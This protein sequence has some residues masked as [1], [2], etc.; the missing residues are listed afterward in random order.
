MQW[1]QHLQHIFESRRFLALRGGRRCVLSHLSCYFQQLHLISSFI[2]R[3]SGIYQMSIRGKGECLIQLLSR[4]LQ[5][6]HRIGPFIYSCLIRRR[7]VRGHRRLP[8]QYICI[9]HRGFYLPLLSSILIVS[10]VMQAAVVDPLR[11]PVAGI[12]NNFTFLAHSS[13]SFS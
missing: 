13:W 12:P 10:I 1:T 3:I 2:F 8:M 6:N 7:S 4:C 5:V 9:Y 11:S